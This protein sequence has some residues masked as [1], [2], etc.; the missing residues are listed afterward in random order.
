[1]ERLKHIQKEN[2]LINFTGYGF[3][4]NFIIKDLL[5]TD[6]NKSFQKLNSNTNTITYITKF[7]LNE[8]K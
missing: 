3:R 5:L 2:E 8:R 4:K 7:L 1:M 6:K